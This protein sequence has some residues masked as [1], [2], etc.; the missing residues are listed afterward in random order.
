ME[1]NIKNHLASAQDNME[2]VLHHLEIEL[3][4]VRAGKASIGLLDGIHVDY[5][6]VRTPLSQVANLSTPDAKT[7]MIKPWEKSILPLIEKAI[8]AANI[9]LTPQGDGEVI[10]LNLPALTEERRKQL[11]KTVHQFAEHSKVGIRNVR[12]DAN[13]LLKQM[14]KAKLEEDAEKDAED[15]VQK[16]TNTYIEKVDKHIQAKEKEI[17]TV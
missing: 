15:Q 14:K 9:G 16:L 17:M 11:V 8:Q 10:R 13:E 1:F 7:I 5:Y 4:K 6:G 12:R 3:S 2:K